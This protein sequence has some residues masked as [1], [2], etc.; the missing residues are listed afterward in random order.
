MVELH[1]SQPNIYHGAVL[2]SL[3]TGAAL[4]LLPGKFWDHV[5]N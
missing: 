1:L 4:P 3:S 5:L 2:N